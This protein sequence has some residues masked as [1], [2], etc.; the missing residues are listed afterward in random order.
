MPGRPPLVSSLEHVLIPIE[1]R[2]LRDEIR[3]WIANSTY[4][5]DEIAVRFHHRLVF[6]HPFPNGNGRHAR[7][8]ADLL[9]I[10]LGGRR[11]TW[12]RTSLIATGETRKKYVAALRQAD[13]H[14][15]GPILAF[16]RS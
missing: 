5:T 16:A 1:L 6:I 13:N 15:V 11:F 7:L 8:A 9:I 4:S 12:G 3:F 2:H 14:D 10:Q